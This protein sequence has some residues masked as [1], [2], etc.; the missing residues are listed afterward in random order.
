MEPMR[1]DRLFEL[2]GL[3]DLDDRLGPEGRRGR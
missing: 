3:D 1:G 2:E